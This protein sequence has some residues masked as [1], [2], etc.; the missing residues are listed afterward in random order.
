MKI[1]HIS[2]EC[3]PVAKVGGLADVVGTLPKYLN[4]LGEEA[5]V[6]MPFYKNSFIQQ[7][8]FQVVYQSNINIE[9]TE[10]N[11]EVLE[12]TSFNVGFPI[13]LISI[14]FLLSVNYV[15]SHDDLDRFFAFQMSA[16]NWLKTWHK[17]PD[18]IHC[19]DHHAALIPFLISQ[20]YLCEDLKDIATVLT[21]HN[22]EYQGW[23]S[24]QRIGMFPMF[25][26]NKVGLLDWYGMINPLAIAIKA[27]DKVTTVSPN[28]LQELMHRANGLEGLLRTESYK[29]V[30][31]LNGIDT[32]IWNPETDEHLIENYSLKTVEWGK[33]TN[34][35]W[36][37]NEYHL[38]SSKPLI[39]FIGRLVGHKGA[40]LLATAFEWAL[41]K[42]EIS[43][44][45]LGSGEESIEIRQNQLKNSYYS[46][47]NCY[48]GY[49]EQLAHRIY[50]AADF[51]VMPSRVEPCGLNQLYA[52]R[53]G[54]IP[55]VTKVG[56]LK[57]T[58]VDILEPNGFGICMEAINE[59]TIAHSMWRAFELYQNRD[60]FF[61][62]RIQVM[63]K[64]HSWDASAKEYMKLYRSIYQR[65]NELKS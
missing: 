21:I 31:I 54:A 64:N 51:I 14:P 60:R 65:E 33:Q 62:L 3:F 63:N 7:H 61:S 6:I 19:H 29:C 48:I 47:F 57:D 34:K 36:L 30:G 26:F 53:Y 52:M 5:M 40:D 2:A 58:V 18:V 56:G 11:F 1:L 39:V 49:S 38:D 20:C 12:P 25:P 41:Y 59:G 46:N 35:N 15:Y 24:H 22:A 37:C 44:F 23:F 16:L 17:K 13:Y 8:Q 32:E 50:A 45:L 55:I 28:Y 10:F 43:I 42:P 4:D 9:G 27:A